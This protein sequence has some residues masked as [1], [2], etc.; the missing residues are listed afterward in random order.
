MSEVFNFL[1]LLKTGFNIDFSGKNNGT[2]NI[3]N[4][5]G[6]CLAFFGESDFE[7]FMNFKNDDLCPSDFFEAWE[8]A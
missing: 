5:D 4:S 1:V 8:L 3:Y 2:V 7:K 6:E